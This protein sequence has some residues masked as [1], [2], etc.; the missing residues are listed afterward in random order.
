MPRPINVSFVVDMVP[1][2]LRVFRF[3]SVRVIPPFLYRLFI[4]VESGFSFH[5]LRITSR[6]VLQLE[7]KMCNAP[8]RRKCA[9]WGFAI[10]F[11]AS[12]GNSLFSD[13]FY[14]LQG[15]W[16]IETNSRE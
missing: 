6:T 3:S 16:V 13:V 11:R 4:D 8:F 1:G 2:F 7:L 15:S 10:C 12:D 14:F 5:L 9:S